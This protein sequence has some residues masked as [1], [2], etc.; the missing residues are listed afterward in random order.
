M[1]ESDDDDDI[2]LLNDVVRSGRE[3]SAHR[4]AQYRSSLSAD[5]IEAIAARVVERYMPE[6]QQAIALA[7]H[8]ALAD[9]GAGSDTDGPG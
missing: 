5:D 7:I 9:E 3:T 4:G 2:P 6:I 8:Q 1:A